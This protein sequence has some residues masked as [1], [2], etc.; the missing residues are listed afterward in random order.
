MKKILPIFTII[1][2]FASCGGGEDPITGDGYDRS[3]LLANVTDNIIIPACQN[4]Y[5]DVV[6]LDNAVMAFAIQTDPV[7]YTHLTL[8]TKA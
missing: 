4:F 5:D 2:V 6:A 1:A 8:P 3:L 7:S